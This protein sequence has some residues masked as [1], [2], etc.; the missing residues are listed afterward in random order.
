MTAFRHLS[1]DLS[2]LK[3][4]TELWDKYHGTFDKW[5]LADTEKLV[6]SLHEHFEDLNKLWNSVRS[7]HGADDEWRVRIIQ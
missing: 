1:T 5:K 2:T 6:D 4:F 7:Q 3:R